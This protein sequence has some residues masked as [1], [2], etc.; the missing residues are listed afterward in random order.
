M[1]KEDVE[2][3]LNSWQDLTLATLPA[4]FPVVSLS[5]LFI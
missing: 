1:E 3:K 2:E 4:L 5:F